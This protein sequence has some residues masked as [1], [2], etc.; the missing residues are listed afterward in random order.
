MNSAIFKE[1]LEELKVIDNVTA[2][3]VFELAEEAILALAKLEKES[4][5]CPD[6]SFVG[7]EGIK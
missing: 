6:L 1:R 2:N 5:P 3:D 4:E 7:D